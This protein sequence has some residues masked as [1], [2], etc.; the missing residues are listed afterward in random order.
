LVI[1]EK[2]VKS[3]IMH[4]KISVVLNKLDID[5]KNISL[6]VLA[7]IHR[8]IV[9]ERPDFAPEHNERLEFL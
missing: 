4:D 3:K 9:N 1:T 7:F 2:A 6:Y 5:Y 8:S